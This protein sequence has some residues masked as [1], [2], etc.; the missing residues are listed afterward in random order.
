MTAWG[1]V[2]L[3][4]AKDLC[5]RRARSF[6]VLR[7]TG[8]TS[9]KSAHRKSYLQMSKDSQVYVFELLLDLRG[10]WLRAVVAVAWVLLFCSTIPTFSQLPAPLPYTAAPHHHDVA[11]KSQEADANTAGIPR[12]ETDG[13]AEPG[14]GDGESGSESECRIG[15]G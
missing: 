10:I 11:R 7:M 8:R 1:F 15:M 4:A 9:L 5:V 2:I 12:V 3:S 13:D 14:Q 6:A